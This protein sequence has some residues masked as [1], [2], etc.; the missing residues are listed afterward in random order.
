MVARGAPLWLGLALLG[1]CV[2][3]DE[4]DLPAPDAAPD[5]A[6][7]DRCT[8]DDDCQRPE[9]EAGCADG[10]CVLI[11]CHEGAH[12][13]DGDPENGCEYAC[14]PTGRDELACDEVDDDCD[15]LLDEASTINGVCGA[16]WLFDG[17]GEHVYWMCEA[18]V[19]WEQAQARCQA[20]GAELASVQSQ[21]ENDLLLT[22]ADKGV[23]VFLGLNDR[24]VEGEHVWSDGSPVEFTRWNEGEP[25]DSQ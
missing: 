12:D 10:V 11:A 21:E 24:E 4:V 15:G 20:L 1:A 2:P 16:C 14:T 25:N 22:Y 8:V 18:P 9:A 5:L 7:P 17:A 6:P 19:A 3:L 13:L 23:S